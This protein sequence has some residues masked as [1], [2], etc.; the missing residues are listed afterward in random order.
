[1]WIY[2][3]ICIILDQYMYEITHDFDIGMIFNDYWWTSQISTIALKPLLT[4]YEKFEI[5][6]VGR[7]S[8]SKE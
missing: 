2:T 5:K 8:K 1:M 4:L 3:R 7:N 6:G